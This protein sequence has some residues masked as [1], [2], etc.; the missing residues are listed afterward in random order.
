MPATPRCASRSPS[1][2]RQACPG[3]SPSR[4]TPRSDHTLAY[5]YAP[6]GVPRLALRRTPPDELVV[7][8]Y[9]TALA[10][11]VAPH[12]AAANF[13]ALEALRRAARYGFIEALDY[14][15]VA[16]VGHRAL[17]AREHL[18]G[19]P[20]G[21]E[22]RGAR[23]R[24][25][26][27]APRS[28]GAW[29]DP[30]SRRWPRCCTS[31]RRAR[32]RG[33][34][35]RRRARR[36]EP[37][38]Q[39]RARAAARGPAGHGGARADPPAVERPLQRERCAPTARAGAAGAATWC[40]ALAR[41]RAARRLRQLLLPALGPA[42]A[43]GLDHPASRARSAPRDYRARF[44][45]DR[46]CFDAAWPELAGRTSRSGSAPRTTSSS[47]RSSCATWA[48][49]R[50]TLELM[51]SF[52]V[53]LADPRADEAHP[54]FTNLFVQRRVAGRAAGAGVRAQAAPGAPS[55]ACW[56]RTSSPTPTRRWS[57]CGCRPTA[58]AGSAA[59]AAPASRWPRFDEPP[60]RRA[61]EAAPLDTGLDPVCASAVR[62]RI[63]PRAKAALTFATAASD[64]GG[65]LARG[66][67]QV[68]PAQ[69]RRARLADVGHADRHPP[70]RPWASAPRTSPP[71]RR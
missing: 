26:G 37:L 61:A 47:A 9:A 71:S 18:H 45:A 70:A 13:A 62:L 59:T 42:A 67:R 8:P 30:R 55:R 1:P 44:H 31:A 54:A 20:P 56:P 2:R 6:Q 53:T 57:T 52:E 16:P 3:A 10:A 50:S 46:V 29:R 40:H 33:C 60:A 68:P 65:D 69:P 25:A 48:T 23:Q 15:A 27:R 66:D 41:R 19:A 63:A 11:Q 14:H 43:A 7:A 17:H 4:P 5:Q 22:H 49:A 28:A 39:A 32:C 12:R 35:S 64:N 21:H 24:A 36:R 51:S 38:Q 34:T 58:S